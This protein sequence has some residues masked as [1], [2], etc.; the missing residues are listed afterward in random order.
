MSGPVGFRQSR[1]SIDEYVAWRTARAR[2]SIGRVERHVRLNGADVLDVGCGFGSLSTLLAHEGARVRAV[3]IDQ[4][5]LSTARDLAESAGLA[6]DFTLVADE[7]L[8][9]GDECMDV[10]FLFDV[11]EH[12]RDPAA[13][14][15]E[16][17]RVLRP[18][19]LLCA[20]FTPY[21]SITGHHLYDYTKLPVHLMWSRAKVRRLVYSKHVA[22]IFTADDYWQLFESLNKLRV[23]DFRRLTAEFERLEERAI[24]KY[25]EVFEL[26]VPLLRH[27]GRLGETV[28]MSFEGL[29]R[30]PT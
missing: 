29:Y 22:T 10:V 8:P 13:S 30:K 17:W 1:G 18:G 2:P 7:Q 27:L 24:V 6:I 11:I 23:R 20:E 26:N 12:V 5:K 9:L 28:T 19:G 14:L 16:C 3:E 21:Y 4:Q 25:P 15:A